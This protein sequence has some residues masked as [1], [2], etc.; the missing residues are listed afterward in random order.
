[1]PQFIHKSE[2]LAHGDLG[3]SGFILFEVLVAMSLIVSSWITLGDTYQQMNL[4]L[5]KSQEQRAQMKK[6]ADQYELTLLAAD[7]LNREINPI[8]GLVNEPSRVSR[9]PRHISDPSSAIDKK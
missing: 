7:Q 1:V 6:E 2:K 3:S 4:R 5:G 9:R 8:R